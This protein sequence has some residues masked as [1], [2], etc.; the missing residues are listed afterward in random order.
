MS[1]TQRTL[2]KLR[3]DG[4][5]LVE[6]TERWNTFTKTRRDLFNF[7]DVLAVKGNE[8]LAVQT[9]SGTNVSARIAKIRGLQ[10]SGLWLESPNRRIIVHG[11]RK[12]GARGKRK[13]WTCRAVELT[14]EMEIELG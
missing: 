2:A 13:V 10:S 6:V 12:T 4:Y 5:S 14:R 11:W 3:S 1:P 7:I 8:V 9:T